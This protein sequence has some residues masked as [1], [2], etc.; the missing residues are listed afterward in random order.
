MRQVSCQRKTR[1]R[2]GT[3]AYRRFRGRCIVFRPVHPC[4]ASRSVL[5]NGNRARALL[6]RVLLRASGSGTAANRSLSYFTFARSPH[7]KS[8]KTVSFGCCLLRRLFFFAPRTVSRVPK[9]FELFCFRVSLISLGSLC[10]L[11]LLRQ[12]DLVLCCP[13]FLAC[14]AHWNCCVRLTFCD[15]VWNVLIRCSTLSH[16]VYRSL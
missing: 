5:R 9:C 4:S 6:R 11:E 7:C 14:S 13:A 10:A 2:R 16:L 8:H 1:G 15:R 12:D 3:F